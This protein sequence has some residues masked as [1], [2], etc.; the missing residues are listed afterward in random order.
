[1][2]INTKIDGDPDSVR[3]A[4]TWLRSSL[5]TSVRDCGSQLHRART[6]AESGWPGEASSSF[7]GRMTTAGQG[8]DV[9]DADTGALAQSFDHYADSLYSAQS[10]MQRA[11]DIAVRAGLAVHG[12]VIEDPGPDN[13]QRQ[14]FD[15]A[16]READ[17]ANGIVDGAKR[18]A[19]GFWKEIENRKYINAT[20][21]T[22][23]VA[24]DLIERHRS[25]LEKEAQRL[26][27]ESKTA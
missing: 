14:A 25:I 26:T 12:D 15:Q 5:Q 18:F 8:V 7:Q 23:G 19:Q 24:G 3:R 9:V 16:K 27:N 2:P 10:G 1:M 6:R 11:K 21:F 20:D 4:A 17:R 13:H 22:N